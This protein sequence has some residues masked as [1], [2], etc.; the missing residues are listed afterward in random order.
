MLPC[1]RRL[2]VRAVLTP[3]AISGVLAASATVASLSAAESL[4]ASGFSGLLL[5]GVNA[6]MVATTTFLVLSRARAVRLC[7]LP[8]AAAGAGKSCSRECLGSREGSFSAPPPL[9]EE[10][11]GCGGVP[12]YPP[13][14]FGCPL[15]SFIARRRHC[16][17][18]SIAQWPMMF[19]N[20][21]EQLPRN[22]RNPM[23]VLPLSN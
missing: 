14:F 12:R 17:S 4:A 11:S 21:A 19:D 5:L 18:L 2:P 9:E 16:I 15:Q 7:E 1:V 22:Q 20:L 3:R 10:G 8:L 6:F 23:K 13:L